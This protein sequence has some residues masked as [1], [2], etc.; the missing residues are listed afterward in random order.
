MPDGSHLLLV[1]SD[2]TKALKSRGVFQ[3][4]PASDAMLVVAV[5]PA[6]WHLASGDR[7]HELQVAYG[8]SFTWFP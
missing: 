3:P 5:L 4:Q 7:R 2:L 6:R 8:T 1:A